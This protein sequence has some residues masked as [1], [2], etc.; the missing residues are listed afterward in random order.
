M[1]QKEFREMCLRL[2]LVTSELKIDYMAVAVRMAI[3]VQ[4]MIEKYPDM[5]DEYRHD[6]GVILEYTERR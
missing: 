5:Q 2:G 6:L 1:K 3:G 4:R